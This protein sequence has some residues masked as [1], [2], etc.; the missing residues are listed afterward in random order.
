YGGWGLYTD[1]GSSHILFENN[2]VY[3]TKTGGFHQ[4]YG[5]ENIVRNNILAFAKEQ[6]LQVSRVED[7]L[8][9]T[10]ENN[11]LLWDEGELARGPWDRVRVR[12]RRNLYWPMHGGPVRFGDQSFEAWQAAGHDE[13]SLVADP[14]FLNARQGDF[15]LR[16]DS[17]AL[18][19]GFKPFDPDE[20]GVRGPDAWRRLARDY[21]W[22]EL[23]L[24][25]PPPPLPIRDD[26]E[27][28][29]AGQ[30]SDAA[31]VHVENRG[32][33]IAVTDT[34]AASG[35]HSL[36]IRDAPG[37]ERAFNP[38][39]VYRPNHREGQTRMEF[40]L[41]LETN[42]WLVVEWRDY[43][44]G[45]Y[46]T[47]PMVVF[48]QGRLEL[49]GQ[50]PRPLPM[51][52]WLHCRIVGGLGDRA[53]AGWSFQLTGEDVAIDF[54]GLPPAR[55]AFRELDWVGFISNARQTTRVYLDNLQIVP[56]EE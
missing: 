54:Q 20:A 6:Q 31:E 15:R 35:R 42:A 27:G 1:E 8:S 17:P 28:T 10:F 37:L 38:H 40:D 48:R 51:D 16:P 34:T 19:L 45:G 22:P 47:G 33:T 55:K 3:R 5:R 7:H 12:M 11:I 49:P 21:P 29:P 9:F 32:D 44:G 39:L 23:Q 2:L 25:P 46:R 14:M 36:E 41:R 18:G 24:P 56:S 50:P 52:R 13:G 53:P 26:F 43:Q 4:H 30:P